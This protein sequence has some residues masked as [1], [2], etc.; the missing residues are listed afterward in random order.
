MNGGNYFNKQK[1]YKIVKI[2]KILQKI[3]IKKLEFIEIKA[4]NK[5]NFVY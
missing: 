2:N 4:L 5:G 3:L 1:W